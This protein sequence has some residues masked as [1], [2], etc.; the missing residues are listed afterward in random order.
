MQQPSPASIPL[1]ER[2]LTV[3]SPCRWRD[4]AV[5]EIASRWLPRHIPVKEFVVI[6][7]D[8]DVPRMRQR[9]GARA[10]VE[11]ETAF[12]P[13]MTLGRL[14]TLPVP[15]FPGAAGWYYQQFL[16]LRYAC[17]DPGD[18]HYLIWDADTVP[19]RPLRFF[20]ADGRM[21]LTSAEE[22][23][24]PYFET[25]RKLLG[26][27]PNR[28]CSF[29]AQHM[30]VRK[31]VCR[32]ML[33]RIEERLPAEGGWPWSIMQGL[34]A[35]GYNLFSEYETYGHYLKNHHP[36]SMRVV[37]RPW[38]RP[39]TTETGCPIPSERQLKALAE[40]YDFAA[41]ERAGPWWRRTWMR[42]KRDVKRV[43]GKGG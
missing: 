40:R 14:R 13:E 7:P 24:P 26:E 35:T 31:S 42:T 23:H 15:G 8:A 12:L 17:V 2:P 10:R 29:I 28:T 39:M 19:L 3:I 27:E 33:R 5:L 36:D 43:L 18:D 37:E 16:K 30:L 9:L 25:Y 1:A 22:F 21:L 11:P 6:A 34:P 41:F 38:Y 32:D 4:M 20:D